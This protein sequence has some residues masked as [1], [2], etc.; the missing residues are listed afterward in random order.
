MALTNLKRTK[1]DKAE[2]SDTVL[3]YD[4]EDYPYGLQVHLDDATIKK[5]AVGPL[6]VGR[7]V[8]IMAKAFVSE[9]S[10]NTH[11]GKPRRSA[12]LQLTDME[13]VPSDGNEDTAAIMY[14]DDEKG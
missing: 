7:A 8:T 9:A 11:K 1:E 10:A 5:L 3:G 2:K 6:E 14:N 13:V 4:D 12:T